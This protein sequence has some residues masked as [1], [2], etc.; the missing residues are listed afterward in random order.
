MIA[1]IQR[2][3]KRRLAAVM[4]FV[5]LFALV[6][7]MANACALGDSSAALAL[8]QP[9]SPHHDDPTPLHG[10]HDHG[11]DESAVESNAPE[12]QDHDAACQKFCDDERATVSF[13]AKNLGS[14]GSLLPVL[15]QFT[16]L[17]WTPEVVKIAEALPADVP[18]C[19]TGPPIP[20]RLLRLTI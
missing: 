7:G 3:T 6:S 4:L 5:W 18:R 10:H 19:V 1:T 2:T 15:V 8:G 9:V 11:D 14:P 12:P 16:T 17:A 13:I 20:I